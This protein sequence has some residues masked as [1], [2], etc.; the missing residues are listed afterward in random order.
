M[1]VDIWLKTFVVVATAIQKG[2]AVSIA[3]SPFAS[4]IPPIN[5]MA[6]SSRM[7]KMVA[8]CPVSL[9]TI[10]PIVQDAFEDYELQAKT[11]LA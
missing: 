11:E 7:A 9:R 10:R 5:T 8:E 2:V 1:Y 6:N 3:P 4:C